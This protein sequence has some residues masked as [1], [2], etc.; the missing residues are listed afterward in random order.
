VLPSISNSVIAKSLGDLSLFLKDEDWE[1]ADHLT[2]DLLLESLEQGQ[3]SEG[4][5]IQGS[6]SRDRLH[7]TPEKLATIPCEVIHAIDE[8]W[9][10]ASGGHFGFTPQLHVY[11]ITLEAMEFDPT[12][13][14]WATPH[15][16]FESVG[17]LMLFPW[18]PL[19]FLK[20]YNQLEFDLDAPM[21]HL[22]ALWYWRLPG[23]VSLRMG[24][25][26]T[27][28]GAGF[29]DLTRLDAMMLRVARC[30]QLGR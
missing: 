16:F 3:R 14:N 11:T 2:A 21:G 24:G 13:S 25:F 26:L 6:P 17:W 12:L 9:Q 1:S 15:P 5:S 8:L 23:L 29:G 20:F 4:I 18:R 27:G 7:F 19:G 30:H 22:P 28:Q 10:Q